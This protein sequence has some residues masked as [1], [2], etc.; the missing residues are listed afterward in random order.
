MQRP[1]VSHLW[2]FQNCL[3]ALEA[4]GEK[5]AKEK[6]EDPKALAAHAAKA[7]VDAVVKAR[8]DAFQRRCVNR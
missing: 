3:D 5:K 2:R 7:R 8:A 1:E 6:E 4:A